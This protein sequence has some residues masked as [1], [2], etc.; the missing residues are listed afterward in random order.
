MYLLQYSGAT[1]PA[2]N[3][4]VD[5]E[6][7][8][9]RPNM[10]FGRLDRMELENFKSY[11]GKVIVG[12]FMGFNAVIGTNG[13]GKSNLMDAISF[14]LG[15]RTSQLRGNQLRD[16]VYR[17]LSDPTD[18]ARNRKAVVKLF[19]KRDNES[20]ATSETTEFSRT[21]TLN[22]SSEYR[23]NGKLMTLEKY[24]RELA[25]IGILVK[26]RNFLVFQN[27]V[28]GIA[29]KSPS[30]LTELFEEVS[31]SAEF[32]NAYKEAEAEKDAAEEQV[33]THWQK[34]KGM[35]AEK[36][37]YK[38][39]KEE[40]E[41]YQR[42]Q[43]EVAK[44]KTLQ[45]M[46][47]LFHL[48]NEIDAC[49]HDAS[50]AD[51]ELTEK[52]NAL[53]QKHDAL[54]ETKEDLNVL[55][56]R[57][58]QQERRLKRLQDEI[59]K[60]RPQ[61]VKY[62]TEL[63][64]AKRRMKGDERS[65]EKAKDNADTRSSAVES[66]TEELSKVEA[67]IADVK[68]EIED[69]ERSSLSAA[70]MAEY[71]SLK[72]I[73]ATRTSALQ[74]A[75]S[76]AE[77]SCSSAAKQKDATV[78]RYEELKRRHATASNDL[79]TY[80]QRVEDLSRQLDDARG[81]LDRLS[82]EKRRLGEAGGER[83]RV[84]RELERTI[85]QTTQA[86][87]DV[88]AD[89]NESSR[90]RAFNAALESMQR[91][92]PGVLGRLS[93]LCKPTQPRYREAIAVLFGKL[94][95]AIVVDNDRTGSECI[96]FMKDQRAGMATFIPLQSIRPQP[97]EEALRRLGG[98]ARLVIDVVEHNDSIVKAVQYAAANAVV[99]DTL[100]EARRI[101]YDDGR[102]IK[103]C[104]LDGT[105]ISKAGF[106]TGGTSRSAKDRAAQWDRSEIEALKRKRAEAQDELNAMGPAASD[107]RSIA[108]LA[109]K[110]DGIH[111]RVSILEL[112]LNDATSRASAANNES[113][114]CGKEIAL[115]EKQVRSTEDALRKAKAEFETIQKDLHGLENE[116]FG[117][118]AQRHGISTVQEFESK[119]VKRGETL[120]EKLLEL[121]TKH[122]NVSSRLKY[123]STTSS[124][125]S[126]IRL[127][128]KIK[129]HEA[130]IIRVESSLENLASKRSELLSR[131]ER[132]QEQITKTS[133]ER[134]EKYSALRERRQ[135]Y[136]RGKDSISE[137]EASLSHQR[138]SIEHLRSKRANIVT[139]ARLAQIHICSSAK[140]TNEC[141]IRD[142]R[143]MRSTPA[144]KT[145][146]SF[147]MD[148]DQTNDTM[149]DTQD[150]SQAIV[151]YSMLPSTLQGTANA[152]ADVRA[153]K[154]SEMAERIASATAQLDTM[155]PNMR[156][157]EHMAD[158]ASKLASTEREA[159]KARDRAQKANSVF[160]EI[161]TK[162]ETA[163]RNCFDHVAGKINE[164]YKQLTMSTTYTMGGTAYLSLEQ[165]GQP[166]L[167]GIK[168][169]AMPPTKR[170][171]D[172]DQLSGGERTVAALA[173]LF[174]IHDYRPS[175]FF[176]LD[177]IDAALDNLNVGKVSNYIRARSSDLQT[178]VISLKDAFF[179]KADALLGI[180]RDQDANSSR[181][182]TVD[183]REYPDDQKVS[184][185]T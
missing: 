87:R 20:K 127:E 43:A 118:F 171:R 126:V 58:L 147:E 185:S 65:L 138:S 124:S 7:P 155:A 16:L 33:T 29:S 8:S 90:E 69:I 107:R 60:F 132:L 137:L 167:G 131:A 51:N 50:D 14:V 96:S 150:A 125:N 112:D 158:V 174:A 26:A 101:R 98:T 78:T 161:I 133:E 99:C 145:R 182:L 104:S 41:K 103:I 73:A 152:N 77:K 108:A 111:R 140:C 121:E 10:K 93:D 67:E 54:L 62:K 159:E 154:S 31:G 35:A 172:M 146:Q 169:N 13:S 36:R 64:S 38:Q 53:K 42:L 100:D 113:I 68:K 2:C 34:R 106:M 55:D 24:N 32:K 84:R 134:E 135:E 86:L 120:R 25:K 28:E 117:D 4:E 95:N 153:R 66:L 40:A 72:E 110:I 119:Y 46:F 59:D 61:E 175:P 3:M 109:E 22:G 12:P 102:K 18:D 74:Q 144:R 81:E 142:E 47:Q 17:N 181:L 23:I 52:Q 9:Q 162:R 91:L 148:V 160:Q 173:L 105:L 6:R 163:F 136:R 79:N 48:D 128:T 149:D 45:A 92:F 21:V 5:E 116:L 130:Q 122:S 30:E 183:L 75:A 123:E 88:K 89:M 141:T 80:N 139:D 19:Y 115:L 76:V 177:E 94:M 168:Y 129:Q 71:R 165:Q 85:Q 11:G 56:K 63:N 27:E 170:F 166:Y 70:S 180:Y 157:K 83:E 37:Q 184:A 39:Q 156:A 44:L 178:I 97:I 57:R 49:K 151:D 164:I 15:V 143:P 176:V 114:A 1:A 179:E 82:V